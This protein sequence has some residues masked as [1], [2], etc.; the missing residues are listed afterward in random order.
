MKNLK[1]L[2]TAV[3]LLSFSFIAKAQLSGANGFAVAYVANTS[4]NPAGQ[5]KAT[6]APTGASWSTTTIGT[7]GEFPVTGLGPTLSSVT[8]SFN[9]FVA[10]WGP[11]Q[12][13][14]IP[15]S[16]FD[17]MPM[18]GGLT[19]SGTY[20]SVFTFRKTWGYSIVGATFAY[21]IEVSVYHPY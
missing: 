12:A 16:T 13:L 11:Y 15:I 7:K 21:T 18:G 4:A 19:Y 8:F 14:N 1:L 9:D 6:V 2:L 10:P 3:A 17:A 20:F 5:F